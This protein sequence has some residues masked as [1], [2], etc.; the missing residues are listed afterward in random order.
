MKRLDPGRSLYLAVS[1]G[2]YQI[3]FADP[4]GQLA[5]DFLG[6]PLIVFDSK[7]EE[8]KQWIH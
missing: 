5:R 4:L 8:I 2:V 3:V 6:M 7:S 1:N